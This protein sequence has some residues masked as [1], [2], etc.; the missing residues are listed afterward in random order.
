MV[1]SVGIDPV[2]EG[3]L[4]ETKLTCDHRD[5]TRR[6]D[7][8][9]HS[10]IAILRRKG[11]FPPGH[12][13]SPFQTTIMSDPLSGISGA[14]QRGFRNL[15]PATEPNQPAHRNPHA[16]IQAIHHAHK[17]PDQPQPLNPGKTP[18]QH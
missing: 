18:K 2:A 13:S 5:R 10:L 7:H 11:T 16:L 15:Q 6:F 1:P 3:T 14:P 12:S 17:T 9:P 8:Q 4:D